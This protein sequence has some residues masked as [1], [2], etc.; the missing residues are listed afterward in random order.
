MNSRSRSWCGTFNNYEQVDYDRILGCGSDYGVIGKE[1]GESGTPHLQFFLYFKNAK[2]F[3]VV[4]KLCG[5]KAHLEIT[6]GT[7]KQ[8][9]DYCK[10]DKDFTEWGE[11]PKGQGKRSDI[12]DIKDL[13]KETGKLREVVLE[14]RSVQSYRM[15]EIYLTL[16]EQRRTWKPKVEWYFG[17]SGAGKTY[18]AYQSFESDDVYESMA[19]AKWWNGYDAHECVLIDEMRKDFC[20]FHELLRLLGEYGFKVETKGGSRQFLAKH[21]VITSCFSP[22]EYFEGREDIYQLIRRIDVIK[23][24]FIDVEGNRTNI[25]YEYD[26]NNNALKTI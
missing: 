6:K 12:D 17:E 25:E 8:A 10:K 22:L 13:V 14:A 5:D 21:I 11:T 20:K 2:T 26:R 23:Q 15:A 19:T 24:F 7:P 9:A 18:A 1:V 4:K 16:H 3:S